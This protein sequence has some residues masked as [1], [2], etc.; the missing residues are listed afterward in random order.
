LNRNK[1]IILQI[2]TVIFV[3]IPILTISTYQAFG[4]LGNNH[5]TFSIK[6]TDVYNDG[7]LDTTFRDPATDAFGWGLGTVT[8]DR[9]FSITP[10]DFYNTTFEVRDIA[11]QGRKVYAAQYHRSSILYSINCFDI[12]DPNNLRRLSYRDSLNSMNSIAVDGD[13]VYGGRISIGQAFNTYNVTDP[14]GLNYGGNYLDFVAS[15]GSVTDIEPDGHLVYYTS[16]GD[17]ID[18]SFRI[19]DAADPDNLIGYTPNW[20]SNKSLGLA[21]SDHLAYIAASDEGFYVLNKTNKYNPVELDH[22][23][24]PGNATDVLID[25]NFAYVTLGS[26]GIAVIDISNPSN[27]DLITIINVPGITSKMALQGNTL[28]VT[29]GNFGVGIFDVADPGHISFVATIAVDYAWDVDLYGGIVVV[30]SKDGLHTFRVGEMDDYSTSF[31]VNSYNLLQAWDVRVVGDIAY[32]AAG[33]DGFYTL[34]VRDPN[35]PFILDHVEVP[36]EIYRKIDVS[37][38]FAYLISPNN[39]SVFDIRDPTN[40]RLIQSDMGNNLG[41]VFVNGE[42]VYVTW[43]AGGYA[44][45]NVTTPAQLSFLNEFAEPHYGTNQTAI[46]VQDYK[47]YTSDYFGGWGIGLNILD[48]RDLTNHYI[49][50]EKA[51]S[52]YTID[53]KVDGDFAYQSDTNWCVVQNITDPYNP[54]WI[55]DLKDNAGFYIKSNAVWNFGPYVITAGPTGVYLVNTTDFGDMVS[56]Q[57]NYTA[58][59]LAV[60]TSGDFTYVANRNELII[61]RHFKSAADTYFAGN[62]LA[63]STAVFTMPNGSI[64]SSKYL[65]CIH[66]FRNEFAMASCI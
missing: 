50:G 49:I 46:W 59:A 34:N 3:I 43:M 54:T 26:E 31:Y 37:G 45:I 29:A 25:G 52:A 27:V 33:P 38:Q 35:N 16:Y 24:I 2:I 14:F 11:V 42:A 18:R 9:E 10:L 51:F 20:N 58:N 47:V 8:S 23:S 12:N 1:K 55:N 4:Y 7:F 6:E 40:L 60:T 5:H 39:M 66:K 53:L 15:T 63:Q 56:T 44:A 32:V 30:S 64:S 17:S 57:Y 61:L 22:I 19:V 62:Y 21:I 65:T 48:Q 36:T 41:D 13:V 28:Y